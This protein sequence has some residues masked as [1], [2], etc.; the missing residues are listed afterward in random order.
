MEKYNKVIKEVL[1]K[2]KPKKEEEK[3]LKSLAQRVL[4]VA[5]E[6]AKKYGAKAMLV[7]SITRDTWLPEKMEFD[8]FILFPSELKE[9]ELEKL[10]LDIGKKV[11]EKM[12]GEYTIEYAQHPYVSGKIKGISIDIVPCYEVKSPEEIKSA[13]DRTPFHVRFIEKNLTKKMAD[14]VR[15]LKKFCEA[16]EIYGADAKTEG[17]SGYVCELLII[18]YKSFLN[19]LKKA[20]NWKP[21]EIIQIK[22]Y[23]SK[24]DYPKLIRMFKNQALILIDPTD[25]NR[26]TCAALS[27]TNFFKF[28]KLAKEFL[29]NP[30]EELFFKKK[31]EPIT[32][33]ELIVYQMKR[34]TE[35]ILIKFV[36]PKVVPD[37]LWPQ[38]RKFAERIQN[39][40]EEV[41][42]EFKVLRKDVYTNEKDL[43][44]VLLEME[45]SKLP[46]IQKRIGPKIFDLDDSERFLEKYK[47]QAITGP[48]VEDNFWCVEVKRKF[49]TAREK[50][51]DSLSKGLDILKAKGIPN[52]IA[53]QL[54]KGFELV[55]ENEKMMELV[56]KD[57]NFGVFLRKY[58]EKESLI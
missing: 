10:G 26:N 49:L 9:K 1:E 36:P 55:Y 58:F 3:K 33:N 12:K 27:S 31:I 34:R 43:A 44:V 5:D 4:K 7:G 37:V 52:H 22:N 42:Y 48:F 24:S 30:R 51:L 28:K 45:I 39:I 40:L 2:I 35:L 17:F 6:E 56:K 14:E 16:N 11:I 50:I 53:E 25:K 46:L 19:L 20:V 54:V 8:V 32:E 57:E 15:L 47:S 18:K 23:Y 38:L 29:E 41:K 13:V 21:G